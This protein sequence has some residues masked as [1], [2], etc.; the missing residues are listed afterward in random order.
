MDTDVGSTSIFTYRERTVRKYSWSDVMA[1]V[2]A[3]M[4]KYPGLGIC[5]NSAPATKESDMFTLVELNRLASSIV[6][7]S[8]YYGGKWC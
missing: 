2:T 3:R 4:E 5:M 7:D 8:L 6:D 1:A